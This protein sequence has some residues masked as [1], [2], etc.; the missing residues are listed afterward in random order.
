MS[1]FSDLSGYLGSKRPNDVVDVTILRNGKEKHI[2][3]TLV[4]L[5][6]F[7]IDDLGLEVR[8]ANSALLKQRGVNNGVIVSKALS[9][10]MA[11]YNLEGIIITKINDEKIE[12][13]DDAKRIMLSLIHIWRCRRRG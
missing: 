4:K 1:K 8:N 10:D 12:D 6:T 3:V 7:E 9:K 5:E 11:R 13:I 2:P